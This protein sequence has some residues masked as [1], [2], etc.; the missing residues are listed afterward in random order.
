M[1][2]GPAAR[3][4]HAGYL[5]CALSMIA[6]VLSL[7]VPG[8]NFVL[9]WWAIHCAAH[10]RAEGR[11]LFALLVFT[12]C[13]LAADLCFAILG[14][15]GMSGGPLL[16]A[17]VLLAGAAAKVVALRSGYAAFVEMGGALSMGDADDDHDSSAL[18][19]SPD[20]RSDSD[21]GAGDGGGG[22]EERA[23]HGETPEQ[24]AD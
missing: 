23:G 11:S 2:G 8:Y 14:G 20:M 9:G 21:E 16:V 12:A 19:H 15:A 24:P 22:E 7:D 10:N 3:L 18:L 17:I 6:E 4:E 1:G 13:S 5:Q